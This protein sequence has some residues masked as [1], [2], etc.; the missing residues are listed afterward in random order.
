MRMTK[1]RVWG[2]KQLKMS[3]RKLTGR[4]RTHIFTAT[5]YQ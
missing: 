3:S 4:V 5:R 2:I 1:L